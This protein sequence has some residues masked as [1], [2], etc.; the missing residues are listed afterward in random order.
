MYHWYYSEK[1]IIWKVI[2]LKEYNE[3]TANLDPN[4]K[5]NYHTNN[6]DIF[7]FKPG[8]WAEHNDKHLKDTRYLI[9]N[10]R[11]TIYAYRVKLFVPTLSYKTT[12]TFKI[13]TCALVKIKEEFKKRQN[14]SFKACFGTTEG[15]YQR[16]IPKQLI[17]SKIGH[18][19]GS[20]SS[21]DF[22]SHYPAC[23]CGSLPDSHTAIS[24][25]GTV[26]PTKE[27]PF[28]FYLKSGHIAI[29]NEVDTHNWLYEPN[30]PF[31]QLFRTKTLKKPDNIKVFDDLF[32]KYV[33]LDEDETVLMKASEYTLDDIW[34][35]FYNI[36]QTYNEDTEE[37]KVAKLVLNAAIGQMHRKVY[38]RDKYAHLAAIIIARANQK[39]IDMIHTI[40]WTDFIQVAT[41]GIMYK[42][43]KQYGVDNKYL[44]A[45][46]QE[47]LGCDCR[48]EGL[49]AYMV[50][51]N[52]GYKI[53]HQ[54]F[55]AMDNDKDIEQ[56]NDFSDMDHWIKET[57]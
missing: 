38:T 18:Y 35:Y 39:A 12:D 50:K 57:N 36:K 31:E 7:K 43:N 45:P 51:T 56:C 41:D 54:C 5:T 4:K 55:D 23:G 28:A 34:E 6:L 10:K 14:K 17:W 42:G 9:V 37:Y 49:N 22:S 8:Y 11:H 53:R 21:I 25:K 52:H 27:Y 40:D 44:G 26:K 29:Y 16:C 20:A 13:N 30:I 3:I 32:N 48:F 2:G 33:S 46:H 1:D 47:Y 24:Y 15:K 19:V